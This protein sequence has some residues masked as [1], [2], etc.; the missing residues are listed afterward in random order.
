MFSGIG[1]L[2]NNI[3]GATSAGAQSQRYA[4]ESA[5]LNNVYQKEFAQNAHQWEIEDLKKAGL[6]PILSAG[7]SGASA[8]GGGVNSASVQ[9]AGVD[10]LSAGIG[11]W[12]G[13][14]QAQNTAKDANLKDAQAKNTEADTLLKEA[15]K[16]TELT[17]GPLNEEQ[18]KLVNAQLK[19]VLDMLPHEIANIDAETKY[20]NERA[21]GHSRSYSG[22]ASFM[23]S[24]GGGSYS[25]TY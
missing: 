7:G 24:G 10:P 2:L 12:Q 6:N 11:I 13:I 18:R 20:T 19:R 17:K 25:T 14:E 22:N 15:Q 1:S 4:I 21:R 8:S 23:G 16:L 9:S 5:M 3:T